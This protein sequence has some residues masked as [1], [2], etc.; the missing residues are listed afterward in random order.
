MMNMRSEDAAATFE[1]LRPSSRVLPT[2]CLA[3]CMTPRI[4]CRKL[5]SAG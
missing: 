4:L 3:P 5:S 1:P 2:G